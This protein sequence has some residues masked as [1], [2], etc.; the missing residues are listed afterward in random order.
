MQLDPAANGVGIGSFVYLRRIFEG[1]IEEAFS[2]AKV[3]GIID[4][5]IYDGIRMDEKIIT[6]KKYLPDFL[7][8]NRTLYGILSTGIHELNEEECLNYY[9]IVKTGIEL[10]LDEKLEKHN[11]VK[12]IRRSKTVDKYGNF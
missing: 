6:L 11:K 4:L 5:S 10:I 2:I 8:D 9:E 7:F 12:K 3:E 1:L